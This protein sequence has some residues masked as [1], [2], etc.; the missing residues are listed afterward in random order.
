[1]FILLDYDVLTVAIHFFPVISSMASHSVRI[2]LVFRLVNL[3]QPLQVFVEICIVMI[4][5]H[6]LCYLIKPYSLCSAGWH[7]IIRKVKYKFAYFQEKR[8]SF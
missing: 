7:I 6:F 4:N 3:K 8:D 1:M 5:E 2:P